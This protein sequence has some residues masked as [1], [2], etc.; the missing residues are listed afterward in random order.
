MTMQP[1]SNVTHGSMVDLY[2]LYDSIQL[3][4]FYEPCQLWRGC[5]HGYGPTLTL[6]IFSHWHIAFFVRLRLLC[7]LSLHCPVVSATI[8]LTVNLSLFSTSS[9]NL[10]IHFLMNILVCLFPGEF[11]H[12]LRLYP[13]QTFLSHLFENCLLCLEIFPFVLGIFSANFIVN[14]MKEK[15]IF[16]LK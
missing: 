14:L 3:C 11:S 7:L 4:P 8:N 15:I 6:P 16:V 10:D 9:V 5:L 2:Y 13:R 1:L 12:F